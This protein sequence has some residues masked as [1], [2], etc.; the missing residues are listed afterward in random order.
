LPDE[1]RDK[2]L[3]AEIMK[4]SRL[5]KQQENIQKFQEIQR[6]KAED[7]DE[8]DLAGWHK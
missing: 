3:D 1:W 5:L 8:D 2:R 7:S 6:R 4:E